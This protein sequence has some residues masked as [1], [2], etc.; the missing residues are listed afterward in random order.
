M[1]TPISKG[2]WVR[3]SQ[4]T[5]LD[6]SPSFRGVWMGRG[7]NLIARPARLGV[8]TNPVFFLELNATMETLEFAAIGGDVPNRGFSEPTASLH[9]I[10]YA[11]NVTDLVS[12]TAI[13]FEPGL[14]LHVPVTAEGGAKLCSRGDNSARRFHSSRKAHF[15]PL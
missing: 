8:A 9:D 10:R 4:E 15:L 12:S 6:Y 13:H 3:L 1:A 11:Q 2:R 7:F 5:I 14:W